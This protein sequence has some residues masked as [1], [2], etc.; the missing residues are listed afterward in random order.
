MVNSPDC[1]LSQY[2]SSLN[3]FRICHSSMRTGK[4]PFGVPLMVS[5]S[6]IRNQ[7]SHFVSRRIHL[8]AFEDWIVRETWNIHKS[9]SDA[10]EIL[11]F[12]V[13]ESLSEYSSDHI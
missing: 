1:T 9:G 6:D 4:L 3:I 8:D 2:L 13:E 10:A 5:A 11:T 12:A 7:I